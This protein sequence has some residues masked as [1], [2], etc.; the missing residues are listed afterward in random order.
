MSMKHGELL[1]QQS[2]AFDRI[3][4][5]RQR[6]QIANGKCQVAMIRAKQLPP[7][8]QSAPQEQLGLLVPTLF[9]HLHRKRVECPR[10]I[11]MFV[12]KPIRLNGQGL[13]SQGLGFGVLAQILDDARQSA[14]R[15]CQLE[16][17][18]AAE[19]FS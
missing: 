6:G 5:H 3:P 7:H 13:T 14:E 10:H 16:L 9:Q 15:F 1:P 11:D 4:V 12:P 17:I 19:A 8:F 18:A 2:L